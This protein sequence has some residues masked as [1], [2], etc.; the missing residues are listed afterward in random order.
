MTGGD[1]LVNNQFC[2]K[3]GCYSLQVYWIKTTL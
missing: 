1:N 3:D 2:V